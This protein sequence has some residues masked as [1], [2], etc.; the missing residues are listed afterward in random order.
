MPISLR[1]T[2]LLVFASFALHLSG[3]QMVIVLGGYAL[4]AYADE[5]FT[6]RRRNKVLERQLD[7]WT[8]EPDDPESESK[9]NLSRVRLPKIENIVVFR[10]AYI[11]LDPL[12]EIS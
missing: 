10:I 1:V 11:M 5:W 12:R 4:C 9:G 2:F 7:G 6:D 8:K 3:W